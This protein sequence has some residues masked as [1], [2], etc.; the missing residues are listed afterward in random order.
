MRSRFLGRSDRWSLMYLLCIWSFSS[1]RPV[2]KEATKKL[3]TC[4]YLFF[5][6]CGS[7]G[8]KGSKEN[9]SCGGWLCKLSVKTV[10]E[11]ALDQ[12][13]DSTTTTR[14]LD[15]SDL[16]SS[17]SSSSYWSF[18]LN[19]WTRKK[20]QFRRRSKRDSLEGNKRTEGWKR[21]LKEKRIEQEEEED[22]DG[23]MFILAWTTSC[24]ALSSRLV[25]V[26]PVY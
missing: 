13:S 24:C 17:S 6:C 15:S 9:K 19:L 7:G 4:L 2:K 8:K 16:S 23:W 21:R 26:S 25:D 10:K 1:V 5:R 18:H 12:L 22:A 14:Q 3:S 11:I 20:I